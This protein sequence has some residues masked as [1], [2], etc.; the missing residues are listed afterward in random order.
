MDTGGRMMELSA[1]L[2]AFLIQMAVFA[3]VGWGFSWFWNTF[4]PLPHMLWW[5]GWIV[6]VVLAFIFGG[7]AKVKG[8]E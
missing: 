3:L 5:Q 7:G 8:E 6:S 4:L 1:L 2:L